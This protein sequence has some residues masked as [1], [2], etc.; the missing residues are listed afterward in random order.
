MKVVHEAVKCCSLVV[1]EIITLSFGASQ[2]IIEFAGNASI[3]N[4][5]VMR[6]PFLVTRG[7]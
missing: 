3:R 5:F 6:W 4:I 1:L 7:L 2:Q